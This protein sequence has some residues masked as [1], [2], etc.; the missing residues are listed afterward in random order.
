MLKPE[1]YPI[2][3]F[4]SRWRPARPPSASLPWT[5]SGSSPDRHIVET[6]FT[7]ARLTRADTT[8]ETGISK[9]TVS[10]RVRRLTEAGVLDA[11][12]RQAGKRGQAG[13]FCRLRPD[14]G[15]AVTMVAGPEGR[16]RRSL[17]LRG[18][19]I[20]RVGRQVQVPTRRCT[21]QPGHG[22]DARAVL[23]RPLGRAQLRGE[24]CR[25]CRP[26][27]RS[28]RPTAQCPFLTDELTLR[29]LVEEQ[30]SARIR[31]DKDVN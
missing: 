8:A 9:R 25:A 11:S 3:W 24:R 5:W 19:L 7:H 6:L 15:V 10:E 20:D 18:E 22:R 17:D 14:L 2:Y 21:A 16:H 26:A 23:T 31:I 29:E 27:D 30:I 4:A 12:G 13:L 28:S 1:I